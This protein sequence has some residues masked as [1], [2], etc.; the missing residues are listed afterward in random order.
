MPIKADKSLRA[1]Y[2]EIEPATAQW[3]RNLMAEGW[4]TNIVGQ[5]GCGYD[6]AEIT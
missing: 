5:A 4:I 6:G 1:Y 3:L 2:N